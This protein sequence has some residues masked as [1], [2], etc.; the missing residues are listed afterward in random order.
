[1]GYSPTATSAFSMLARVRI[2]VER[3]FPLA[4]MARDAYSL[5]SSAR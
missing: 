4:A 1:V 2:V 5:T 3:E